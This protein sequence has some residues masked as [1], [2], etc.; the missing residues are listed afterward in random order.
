MQLHLQRSCQ[1]PQT[2][3]ARSNGLHTV[4]RPNPGIV[5]VNED[6]PVTSS[7]ELLRHTSKAWTVDASDVRYVRTNKNIG[8][9]SRQV[10]FQSF[11]DLDKNNVCLVAYKND[12]VDGIIRAFQQDPH[13]MLRPDDVWLAIMVQFGFYVNDRSEEMRR[14][15]VDDVH[16]PLIR[17]AN[18]PKAVAEVPIIFLDYADSKFYE[19]TAIAGF[20]GAKSS[21]S[22]D[23]D[24]HDTFQPQSGYWVLVDKVKPVPGDFRLKDGHDILSI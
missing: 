23:G 1:L 3:R 14:F 16:F 22:K 17:A 18:V 24:Q 9:E 8:S 7:A 19:T 10:L 13:L 5:G 6:E 11:E 4:T 2:P 12:F 21:A 15:I 20:V